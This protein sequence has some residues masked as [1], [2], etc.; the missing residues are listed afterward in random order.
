VIRVTEN[1]RPR[2]VPAAVAPPR[3]AALDLGETSVLPVDELLARRRR[4]S[5]RAQPAPAQK[6]ASPGSGARPAPPSRGARRSPAGFRKLLAR[7]SARACAL[8]A[9]API[10]LSS[11]V[12]LPPVVLLA[13]LTG[14]AL[15]ESANQ[16]A[17]TAFSL[18][19]P[20]VAAASLATL[21]VTPE[22][23]LA[24]ST[25]A[26]DAESAPLPADPQHTLERAAADAVAEGRYA[27]AVELYAKLARARPDRPV[28][29]EAARI[30]AERAP[31]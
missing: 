18:Q 12:A 2:S 23:A 27:T 24:P 28:Y 16:G 13:A 14:E 8:W 26:A 15:G 31:R 6:V 10:A 4:L 29:L 22:A 20:A 11:C 5:R 3:S 17:A 7:C 19:G 25:L 21:D 30:L 9:R 1:A